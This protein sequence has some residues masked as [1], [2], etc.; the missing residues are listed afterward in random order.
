[1]YQVQLSEK[2]YREAERRAR[3]AGFTTVDEYVADIVSHDLVDDFVVETPNLD[4]LFTPQRLAEIDEAQ[5]Q[6]KAGNFH[7][8][9]QVREHFKRKRAK[10][11]R[12]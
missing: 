10:L 11:S 12:N 2:L 3:E 4:H 6:I 1:M 7:S 9:E 8:S 5:E